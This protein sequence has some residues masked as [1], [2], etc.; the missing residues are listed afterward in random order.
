MKSPKRACRGCVYCIPVYGNFT[1]QG[2]RTVSKYRCSA[3][4]KDC[5]DPREC[6]SRKEK[7]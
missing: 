7:L 3:E 2:K 5:T 1:K 4:H 6:K